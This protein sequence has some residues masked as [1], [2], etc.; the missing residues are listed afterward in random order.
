M[1]PQIAFNLPATNGIKP[2]QQHRQHRALQGKE[3]SP[4][5]HQG[6]DAT[7]LYLPATE[8]YRICSHITGKD[9]QAVW[10]AKEPFL[11]GQE[12]DCLLQVTVTGQQDADGRIQG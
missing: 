6:S 2:F 10:D 9:K 8:E 3:N 4:G 1:V 11:S 12:T 7:V 5:N